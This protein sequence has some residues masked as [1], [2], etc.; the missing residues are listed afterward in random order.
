LKLPEQ[1]AICWGGAVAQGTFKCPGHELAAFQDQVAIAELLEEH[2]VSEQEEGP[3]LRAQGWGVAAAI[4]K[5]N[6]TK[7]IALV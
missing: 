7:V 6:Q 4:L 5:A 1:I 2:G 3:V